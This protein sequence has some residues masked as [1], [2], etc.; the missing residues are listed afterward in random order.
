MQYQHCKAVKKNNE[1][2]YSYLCQMAVRDKGNS[3]LQNKS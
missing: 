1:A 2:V 3:Y